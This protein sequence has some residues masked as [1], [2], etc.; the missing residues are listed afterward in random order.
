M[1][2]KLKYIIVEISDGEATEIL[3]VLFPE[4]LMHIEIYR[5]VKGSYCGVLGRTKTTRCVSAGFVRINDSIPLSE[6]SIKT[7]G[8]SETLDLESRPEDAKL[9]Y[10]MLTKSR[11]IVYEAEALDKMINV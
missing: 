2:N 5:G 3:P 11:H 4:S 8:K 10:I 6:E 9:I 1:G 7:S